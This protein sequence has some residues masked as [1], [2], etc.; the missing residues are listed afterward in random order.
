MLLSQEGEILKQSLFRE[1]GAMRIFPS[2]IPQDIYSRIS[3]PVYLYRP[4]GPRFHFKDLGN[5]EDVLLTNTPTD[6]SL[7]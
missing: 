7:R 1:R 5:L 3:F 4:I 6:F 2:T